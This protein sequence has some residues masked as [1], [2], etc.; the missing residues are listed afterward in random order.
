MG[1][2]E[3]FNGGMSW[4]ERRRAML[5]API[6]FAGLVGLS[7]RRGKV[8]QEA[9]SIE[10][11]EFDASGQPVGLRRVERVVLTDGEW[12]DRLTAQ[13]YHV[14]RRGG[15]DTPFTGTYH[16][17]HAAGLYRCVCCGTGLFRSEDKFD[18]GTG[19]PSYT[20]PADERNVQER[21]DVSLFM[22]RTEVSCRRCGAHLG[23]VFPDGPPPAH[24]RYCMNESALRFSP[25]T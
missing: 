18:S 24:L 15:T 21:K 1:P 8:E 13:Q 9:G 4:L 17:L 7:S 14:T 10:I 25:P 22:E 6:A 12:R 5:I 11:M 2:P 16:A 23:H 19:W 20:V 3:C